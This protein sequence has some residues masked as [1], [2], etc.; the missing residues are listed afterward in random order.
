MSKLAMHKYGKPLKRD[1]KA[2]MVQV[3]WLGATGEVYPYD[4]PH[5]EIAKT[6]K[7]SYAPLYMQ[8]GEWKLNEDYNYVI[9][10]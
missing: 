2:V 6:E 9:D 5:S 8:I 4:A 1:S 7:G 3:G 10:D